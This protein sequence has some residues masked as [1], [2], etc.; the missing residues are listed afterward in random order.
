MYLWFIKKVLHKHLLTALLAGVVACLTSSYTLPGKCQ[1]KKYKK[2]WC[3][4]N[5]NRYFK[6]KQEEREDFN[7]QECDEIPK[8]STYGLP[9]VRSTYFIF[10]SKRQFN[11]M[12]SNRNHKMKMYLWITKMVL[13]KHLLTAL[14]AVVVACLTSSFA[15][16]G[17]CQ[18]RHIRRIGTL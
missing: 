13:H 7:K 11:Q 10:T 15:F 1:C 8:K 5:I 17:K 4:V 9:T 16:P 6:S 14:L 12:S 2:D 18:H 3:S